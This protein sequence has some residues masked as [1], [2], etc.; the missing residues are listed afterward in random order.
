MIFRELLID[1]LEKKT[2]KWLRQ[3]YL[4]I[5]KHFVCRVN[6]EKWYFFN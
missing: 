5:D 6:K 3:V 4:K 1:Y 2:K